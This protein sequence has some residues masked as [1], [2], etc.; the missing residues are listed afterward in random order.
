[1]FKVDVIEVN[2]TFIDNQLLGAFLIDDSI[3]SVE[4]YG[5]LMGVAKDA[6]KVFENTTN[7][8]EVYQ[9]SLRVLEN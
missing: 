4:N 1:M 7:I 9:N 3:D 5:H 8:P 2:R 6:G